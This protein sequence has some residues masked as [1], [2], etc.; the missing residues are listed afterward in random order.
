ITSSLVGIRTIQGAEDEEG[1]YVLKLPFIRFE[2]PNQWIGPDGGIVVD[3]EFD[4]INKNIAY[5]G[6]WGGGVFKSYDAGQ[7]WEPSS[8]GLG[9]LYIE[10]LAINPK[11]TNVVYAGTHKGKL[12]KTIDGGQT[13]T[14]SSAGIQDEAIVYSIAIDPV[15]PNRVYIG[16]RGISNNGGPPWNGVVYKSTDHGDTW[17]PSLS[18]A[19]GPEEEDWA[20]SLEVHPKATNLIYAAT[21]EHGIYLSHDFGDNWEPSN[22]G[23][24]N[25]TARAVVADP[26]SS[27]PK[28]IYMGVWTRSGVFKSVD[29]GDSWSMTSDGLVEARIYDMTIDPIDTDTIYL[30]TFDEGIMKTNNG[31]D[32]WKKGGLNS[33]DIYD[34]AVHTGNNQILLSGVTS[35]GLYRSTDRGINWYLSQKGLTTRS[36]TGLIVD[37]YDPK[38]LYAS[39]LDK[40]VVQTVNQG[41]S[42]MDFSMGLPDDPIYQLVPHPLDAHFM[43]VLTQSSGLWLCMVGTESCWVK[44]GGDLPSST[45]TEPVFDADHPFATREAMDWV[46]F[47]DLFTERL[48]LAVD[49]HVPLLDLEIAPSD[50]RIFYLATAG[51]GVQRSENSGASWDPAGLDGLHVWSVAVDRMDPNTVYA[52]TNQGDE[53]LVT[54][55]GG[56]NWSEIPL[57]GKLVYDLIIPE[58]D[59]AQVLAGTSDGVYRYDEQGWKQLGLANIQVTKL[60]YH[61]T[62]EGVIYAGTAS[63]A[64]VSMDDGVSWLFGPPELDGITVQSIVYDPHLPERVYF[65]TKNFGILKANVTP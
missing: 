15:S 35:G 39:T 37:P 57:E 53:I 8:K 4:P 36:I 34:V 47:E 33:Y 65:A 13:W 43:Y 5:I 21:H 16:T 45:L 18:D 30:S 24:T 58:K 10:S 23:I 51:A 26:K 40:G 64:Y 17:R 20:Y 32:S 46:Q 62:R 61:P 41:L 48:T 2:R 42:W 59:E 7:I 28:I 9:N 63:G 29:A 3:I 31:G 56:Q 11:N 19:G 6:T 1:P 55:N 49:A 50:S 12:Y 25:L 14:Y 38:I 52:A 54:V 27:L 22:T 44:I 60:A